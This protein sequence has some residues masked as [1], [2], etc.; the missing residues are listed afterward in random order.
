MNAICIH[1]PAGAPDDVLNAVAESALRYSSQVAIRPGDAVFIETGG[2]RHLF[3]D[4]ALCARLTALARRFPAAVPPRVGI[5]AHAAEALAFARFGAN[6][7]GRPDGPP[8]RA[9][10]LPFEAFE[11]YASPFLHD[12]DITHQMAALGAGLNALGLRT[13][14]DLLAMPPMRLGER[15]GPNAA[16]LRERIAG[17][18]D[19]AW[20]R[21]TPAPRVE[22]DLDLREVATQEAVADAEGLLFHLKQA[23]DRV[24]ARLR[25]RGL[26]AAGLE[27]TLGFERTRGVIDAAPWVLPLEL[28]V[29]LA[30]PRALMQLLQLRLEAHARLNRLPR[31]VA[32]L[33]L[34]VTATAPGFNPQREAFSRHEEEVEAL[35]SVLARLT[36]KLGE[37]Q[38]YY[39]MLLERHLPEQAWKKQ[40]SPPD[41]PVE[42]PVPMAADASA[43]A[44]PMLPLPP[45]PSRMLQKPLLLTRTEDWLLYWGGGKKGRRWRALSWEGP[46]RLQK[47]WWVDAAAW[48]VDTPARDYWR[49]RTEQGMEL[50]VFTRQGEEASAGALWLQGWWG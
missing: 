15:F 32:R 24:A 7:D 28:P 34:R 36:Q 44:I 41:A 45:R 2:S 18:L 16:L 47:P 35:H 31:P 20:P 38:A 25:G 48:D 23:A 26:R 4:D 50:W 29:P 6:R 46:E 43:L 42:A 27:L 8:L 14:G 49:V 10:S 40:A 19:M 9:G 30:A 39:A 37:D 33:G 13:L 12:D 3:G 21:F 17:R 5:G 1:Y 22:E 11:C